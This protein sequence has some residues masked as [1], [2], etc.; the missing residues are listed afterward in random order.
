MAARTIS[1]AMWTLSLSGAERFASQE[2]AMVS[3]AE[4]MSTVETELPL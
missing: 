2:A 1:R 3:M 4:V